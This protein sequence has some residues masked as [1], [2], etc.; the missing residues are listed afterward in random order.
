MKKK[1]RRLNNKLFH[2]IKPKILN[3][4]KICFAPGYFISAEIN[5]LSMSGVFYEGRLR[6]NKNRRFKELRFFLEA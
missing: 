5:L 1:S 3:I 2:N 4:H 6:S